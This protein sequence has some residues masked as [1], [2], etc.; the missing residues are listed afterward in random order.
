MKTEIK[1]LAK[2]EVEI[3]FEMPA[4]DFANLAEKLMG[5]N[6]NDSQ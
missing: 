6:L 1:K 2:S 5:G 4:E 3:S